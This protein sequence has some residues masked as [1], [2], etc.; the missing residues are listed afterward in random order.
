MTC[1]LVGLPDNPQKMAEDA[2]NDSQGADASVSVD[3]D[4]LAAKGDSN[5]DDQGAEESEGTALVTAT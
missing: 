4:E 5:D 3:I 1:S 2:R